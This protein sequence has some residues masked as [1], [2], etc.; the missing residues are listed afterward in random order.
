MWLWLTQ[1]N[2]DSVV[3][4]G[5]LNNRIMIPLCH[6]ES[7]FHWHL[8]LEANNTTKIRFHCVTPTIQWNHFFVVEL[9]MKRIN[10][11]NS[12]PLWIFFTPELHNENMIPLS[13]FSGGSFRIWLKCTHVGSAISKIGSIEN[14]FLS[15]LFPIFS[16]VSSSSKFYK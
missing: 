10:N 14:N 12:I 15:K 7:W 9:G 3:Q 5:Q 1:R 16:H 6:T 8:G 13:N 11:K 2:C 4:R